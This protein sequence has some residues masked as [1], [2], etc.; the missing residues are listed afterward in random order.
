MTLRG[1]ARAQGG[2]H[3][4]RRRGRLPHH[5]RQT[6]PLLLHAPPGH[7]Q[8]RDQPAATN[9]LSRSL[10]LGST[11]TPLGNPTGIESLQDIYHDALRKLDHGALYFWYG[12]QGHIDEPTIV[13]YM[14]PITFESIHPGIVR[15]KER[16]VTKVSGVYGWPGDDSLHVVHFFDARGRKRPHGFVTTVDGD[17]VRTEILLAEGES[18][19]I[20]KRARPAGFG[21]PRNV[22]LGDGE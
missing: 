14:Y 19:V 3:E 22:R 16:I 9:S 20:E 13:S 17:G 21:G 2:R 10:H 15:G 6:R 18:A 1:H 11:V 5:Q 7:L 8:L 12:E 4:I